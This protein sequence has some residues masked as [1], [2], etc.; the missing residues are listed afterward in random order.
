MK[1]S[2]PQ[3]WAGPEGTPWLRLLSVLVAVLAIASPSEGFSS[4][5]AGEVV[6]Q[7]G[8]AKILNDPQRALGVGSPIIE[9][10][11]LETGPQGHLHIKLID[12]GVLILRPGTRA[13]ISAYRQSADPPPGLTRTS[14]KPAIAIDLSEGVARSVTGAWSKKQPENFRMSTPVAAIGVRGTD[15]SVYTDTQVTRAAVNTGIIQISPLA[16]P[17]GPGADGLCQ[18]GPAVDLGAEHRG[19]VAQITHD[20]PVVR[21]LDASQPGVHPD[22]IHPRA[23][24]EP[25]TGSVNRQI[26]VSNTLTKENTQTLI[27]GEL[28]PRQ[29][30][31]GRWAEILQDSEGNQF[32]EMEFVAG[33]GRFGIFRDKNTLVQMPSEGIVSFTLRGHEASLQKN[34]GQTFAASID[35]AAL[36]MDFGSQRFETSFRLNSTEQTAMLQAKG[37]MLP[38]GKFFSSPISSNVNVTGA[39]AG[40][41]AEQAG[42]VF[43]GSIGNQLTAYGATFWTR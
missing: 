21:F 30:K 11:L 16:Q 31:W 43:N 40:P 33:N 29:V 10:D 35:N 39:L 14:Q 6:F 42:F 8:S 1:L 28:Q 4:Q 32:S 3:P 12:K 25:E 5:K 17:C 2:F 24:E 15:F 41:S 19:L 7:K 9:G 13:Q 37:G 23:Q 22:A 38:D 20:T 27:S 26:S 36:T 18:R 34:T